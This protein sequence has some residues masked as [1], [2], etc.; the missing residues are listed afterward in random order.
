M[1]FQSEMERA[2]RLLCPDFNNHDA[3]GFCYSDPS[4]YDLEKPESG[5]YLLAVDSAVFFGGGAFN[6][7]LLRQFFLG[8][9]R[10]LDEAARID[11]AGPFPIFPEG[12]SAAFQIRAGG[13]GFIYLFK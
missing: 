3:A 9:P 8:I 10:E 1:L 13:G 6:I 12:D 5:G 4:V 11:G 2:E 7:F